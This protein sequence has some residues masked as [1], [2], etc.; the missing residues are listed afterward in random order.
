[1]TV[2]PNTGKSHHIASVN[3]FNSQP[4]TPQPVY[5]PAPLCN[6]RFLSFF[7]LHS[8]SLS[9]SVIGWLVG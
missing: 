2:T 1:M 5:S 3:N 7:K 6:C 8:S 4:H 9:S